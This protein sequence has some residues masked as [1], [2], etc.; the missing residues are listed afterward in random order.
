MRFFWP[1]DYRKDRYTGTALSDPCEPGF[2]L[3]F[4]DL[5]C[6]SLGPGA[7]S[8]SNLGLLTNRGGAPSEETVTRL[9]TLGGR[10]VAYE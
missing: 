9:L 6:Y 1:K 7:H 5:A 2:A 10:Y 4:E 3:Y 8:R